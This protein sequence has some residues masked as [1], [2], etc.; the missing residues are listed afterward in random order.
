MKR[1]QI[2]KSEISEIS[3]KLFRVSFFRL[4]DFALQPKLKTRIKNSR[5]KICEI[6]E[7]SEVSEFSTWPVKKLRLDYYELDLQIS[8]QFEHRK[9]KV[10]Q[11]A[12]RYLPS[13]LTGAMLTTLEDDS[14]SFML[15]NNQTSLSH[16][17]LPNDSQLEG[18]KH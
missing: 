10:N 1:W 17:C 13:L 7:I 9:T 8:R 18:M 11:Y 14:S 6:S 2:E 5:K 3:K 4:F 12:G 15:Q 16:K